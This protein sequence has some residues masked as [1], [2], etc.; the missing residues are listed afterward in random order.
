[1]LPQA[2]FLQVQQDITRDCEILV[3]K[4][5]VTSVLR[6]VLCNSEPMREKFRMFQKEV[7]FILNGLFL[8]EDS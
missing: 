1:M 6:L 7:S 5:G 8:S 3:S 4:N 2:P